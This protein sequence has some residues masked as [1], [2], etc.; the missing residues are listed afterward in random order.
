MYGPVYVIYDH[1]KYEGSSLPLK[2]F[3]TEE[4]AIAY[5]DGKNT[6]LD[7]EDPMNDRH[8]HWTRL[9]ITG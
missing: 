3:A 9:E 6:K 4:A 1:V 2:A 8:Y 7:K 5:C